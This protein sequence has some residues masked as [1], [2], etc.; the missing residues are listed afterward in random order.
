VKEKKLPIFLYY[1]KRVT[2]PFSPPSIIQRQT[3]AYFHPL[4]TFLLVCSSKETIGNNHHQI[5]HA[6]FPAFGLP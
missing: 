6:H 3:R 1:G 5:M 2:N 4:L